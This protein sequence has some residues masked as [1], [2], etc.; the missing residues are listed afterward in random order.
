MTAA[1]PTSEPW[2]AL[3]V[4]SIAETTEYSLLFSLPKQPSRWRRREDALR[5]ARC[6]VRAASIALE[7]LHLPIAQTL[8]QGA[9]LHNPE[10]IAWLSS[11]LSTM[12][13][14]A[15]VD[16]ILSLLDETAR[17]VEGSAKDARGV[18]RRFALLFAALAKAAP[19]HAMRLRWDLSE[20][21]RDLRRHEAGDG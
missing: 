11:R 15:P 10:R 14:I 8:A 5:I 17:V 12:E 21:A 13:P 3:D 7:G 1:A 2:L 9:D 18:V 20:L 4:S 19:A 16:V 6:G